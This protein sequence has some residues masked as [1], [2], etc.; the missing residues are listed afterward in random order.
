ML[1][2]ALYGGI[3]APATGGFLVAIVD[4]LTSGTV[5]AEFQVRGELLFFPLVA[6]TSAGLPGAAV[7]AIGAPRLGTA[8][9]RRIGLDALFGVT[10]LALTVAMNFLRDIEYTRDVLP[11]LL[12]PMRDFL[13]PALVSGVLCALVFPRKLTA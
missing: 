13:L 10:A 1:V 5:P 3:L 8:T 6:I 9:L 11:A 7:G 4:K 2:G 12:S